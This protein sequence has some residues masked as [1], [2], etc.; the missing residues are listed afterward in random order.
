M[1]EKMGEVCMRSLHGRV[2]AFWC[3]LGGSR[4][5]FLCAIEQN[6]FNNHAHVQDLFVEL[7]QG[8]L[9]NRA[10]EKGDGSCLRV[11]EPLARTVRFPMG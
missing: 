9:L 11:R 3:P 10:R 5:V 1:M 6:T 8:V 4:E 7:V 2:A